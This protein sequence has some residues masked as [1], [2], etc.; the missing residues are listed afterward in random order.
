MNTANET[1]DRQE[2]IKGGVAGLLI[3]VRLGLARIGTSWQ[4]RLI[5]IRAKE[6][7]WLLCW[8]FLLPILWS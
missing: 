4:W 3:G 6:R 5:A 2:R 1:L 8:H 7:S